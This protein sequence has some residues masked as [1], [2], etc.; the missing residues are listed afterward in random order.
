MDR[1][2][3]EQYI[4]DE[5]GVEL[6]HLWMKF[7]N[8]TVFRHYSNRKWFALI[9]DIAQSKI[10]IAVTDIIDVLGIRCDPILTE[11]LLR[12]DGFY[13]AYHMNK[14]SWITITLNG[15]VD[16]EKIKL[17]LDMSFEIA[18]NK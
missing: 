15:R 9:M 16:A 12:E 18:G 3:L 1:T 17:L 4:V 6:E 11:S 8:Y 10:D 14:N 5:Y 7:P 13:P 2:V